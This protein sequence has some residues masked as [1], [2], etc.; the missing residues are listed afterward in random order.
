M[1]S[2]SSKLL[3]GMVAV[4][5]GRNIRLDVQGLRAVAVLAVLAYHANSAWL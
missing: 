3:N 5:S 2:S 1:S 4:S